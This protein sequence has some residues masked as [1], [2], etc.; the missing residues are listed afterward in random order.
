MFTDQIKWINTTEYNP[1]R[2]S[3]LAL[4]LLKAAEPQRVT[5]PD[6]RSPAIFRLK[7]IDLLVDTAEA[8]HHKLIYKPVQFPQW[9]IVKE[10]NAYL[11]QKAVDK[12]SQ[13]LSLSRSFLSHQ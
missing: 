3:E 4:S 12:S 13:Q 1:E 8:T 9:G 5:A 7:L 10:I 6:N 11:R 2:F